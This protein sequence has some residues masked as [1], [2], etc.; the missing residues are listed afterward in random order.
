M[1]W[2]E[3]VRFPVVG[4]YLLGT[5]CFFIGLFR[6]NDTLKRVATRS[7]LLGFGAH[8]LFLVLAFLPYTLHT[9]PKNYYLMLLSW[10]L[11]AIFFLA[12]LKF[13]LEFLALIASPLALLLF[14]SSFRLPGDKARMPESL[15]VLFFGLHIG[16]LFF[17]IG[18]LALAFG[19]G[20]V[21]LHLERKIKTKERL[22][23]FRK[24]LPSLSTF[25]RANHWAVLAGF[26]LYTLGMLSG[27]VWAQ[28]T[29]GKVL[30]WD[31]KEIISLLIWLVFAV[32]FHQRLLM[33][34][35]GRKP[36][37]LAI[38]VFGF[39][40]LSLVGVNFFLDTHHSLG[41]TP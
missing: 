1:G 28:L 34:W 5:I 26:P 6:H 9:L 40:M 19:S 15:S 33:G 41:I 35:R 4:C 17:S 16:S 22:I 29:W 7:A 20:L 37:L 14:V 25:D 39:T 18:L 23:G 8:T 32:L 38:W 36:A 13:K 11:L 24:D 12:W 21:F 10:S 31:P 27:F 30:T 2:P 3:I